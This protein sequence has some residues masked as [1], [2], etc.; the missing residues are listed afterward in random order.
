MVI[1]SKFAETLLSLMEEKGL[2]A[3]ALAKALGTDRSNITR[4]LHGQRL[5]S[6]Q[7]FINLIE[8]FNVSADVLLGVSDYAQSTEFLPLPPFGAQL[9]TIMQAT[10]TTQYALKKE[11]GFSS[12][13]I[14]NWLTGQ[15]FPSPDK[16]V[17]LADHMA[18]SVD[19]LLGRV[20]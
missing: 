7:V 2:N 9:R 18:V 1:L 14:H 4:Y 5:P 6:F 15:D 19:Y 10:H 12:A 3:P 16:L 13:S 17:R 11:A 20:K 8:F